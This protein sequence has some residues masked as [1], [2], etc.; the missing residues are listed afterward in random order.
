VPIEKYSAARSDFFWAD[1][2]IQKFKGARFDIGTPRLRPVEAS[3][4]RI[5]A[6]H[7]RL[8]LRENRV[9]EIVKKRSAPLPLRN[10]SEKGMGK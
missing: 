1:S 4:L 8:Q 5:N 10:R 3:T 7:C 2:I 9:I 6:Q